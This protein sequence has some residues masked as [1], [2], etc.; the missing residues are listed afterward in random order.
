MVEYAVAYRRLM[1]AP[2]LWVA[3]PKTPVR[4]VAVILAAQL[5][6]KFE[7]FILDVLL[8]SRHVRFAALIALKDIPRLEQVFWRGYRSV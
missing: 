7:K 5:P 3:D 6:S 2:Y 1:Y 8:E 4:P